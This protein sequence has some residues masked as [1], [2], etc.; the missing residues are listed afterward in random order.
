MAVGTRSGR[1]DLAYE[2]G[3]HPMTFRSDVALDAVDWRILHELQTDGR[4]SF[5]ELARRV[6]L[7]APAVADRVRRLQDAGVITGYQA[8]VDPARAGLPLTAFLML[9]CTPG[10]CLLRTGRAADYPE[11]VEVHK[12][13]SDSC[14]LLKVR[15]ASMTHLESFL[16]HL[17]ERHGEARSHMVLSTQYERRE[18]EAPPTPPGPV[19]A[20]DGW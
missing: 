6:N 10:R 3:W 17:S 14:A 18:V 12:L 19:T 7:S 11:I 4:Q 13:A 16:E 1:P 8:R 15:V 9:R 5:K 20:A 2:R